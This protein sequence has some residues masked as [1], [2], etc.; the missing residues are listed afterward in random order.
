MHKSWSESKKLLFTSIIVV[1]FSL[2]VD[3]DAFI[4][5]DRAIDVARDLTHNASQIE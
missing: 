2:P 4:P 1:A 5:L 3:K